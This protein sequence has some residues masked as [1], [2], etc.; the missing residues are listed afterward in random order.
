MKK[1][2]LLL[3]LL[4][5]F[6]CNNDC[7]QLAIK[8]LPNLEERPECSDYL[9]QN[10]TLAQNTVIDGN[11]V[12]HGTLDLN[13]YS[14]SVTGSLYAKELIVS[15]DLY[16][17][18]GIGSYTARLTGGSIVS[19]N[20]F[21]TTILY[22]SGDLSWCT[23]L[24]IEVDNSQGINYTNLCPEAFNDLAHMVNVPCDRQLPYSET[25]DGV[26]WIYVAP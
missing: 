7:E 25:H 23:S 8:K 13:G 20:R 14:L 1:L 12:V 22:G 18:W 4:L 11:L 16:A 5:A 2:L 10:Y 26:M 3:A 17:R 6:S 9:Y 21:H 24:E 19:D 15:G